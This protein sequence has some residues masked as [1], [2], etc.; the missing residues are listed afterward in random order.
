[1]IGLV[2]AGIESLLASLEG[3]GCRE[4]DE[5]AYGKNEEIGESKRG[6]WLARIV[7]IRARLCN[8]S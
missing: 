3:E 7:V 6:F 8:L 5:V 4:P 2:W 1:M